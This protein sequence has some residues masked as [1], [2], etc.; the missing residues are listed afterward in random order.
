[1]AQ[2]LPTFFTDDV[3]VT[4]MQARVPDQVD[5]TGM[6]FGASNAP[7]IG[8]ST[9]NPGLEQSLPNWTLLDQHGDARAAQI[10]QLIGGDGI[11]EAADWP[12][13]G[14]TIG[15]LPDAVVR[16]GTNP[17]NVNGQPVND[18]PITKGNGADLVLLATGWE[19]AL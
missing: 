3:A 1:M 16:F 15:T 18:T 2:A 9:E 5:D 10:S 8:I 11:T 12:G 6:N 19:D 17:A 14:G 7:G 4:A 13:S